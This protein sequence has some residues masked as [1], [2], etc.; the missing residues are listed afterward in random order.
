MPGTGPS[1]SVEGTLGDDPGRDGVLRGGGGRGVA[2]TPRGLLRS[3]LGTMLLSY[4]GHGSSGEIGSESNRCLAVTLVPGE[5][6]QG[7]VGGTETTTSPGDTLAAGH[8][9][10]CGIPSQGS[11]WAETCMR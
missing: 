2:P 5:G 7:H 10:Q 9:L 6:V 1:N 3:S 4:A 11:L 8:F